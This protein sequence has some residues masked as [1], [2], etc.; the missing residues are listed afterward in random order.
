MSEL[1]GVQVGQIWRD[2]DK[3]V[4]KRTLRVIRIEGEKAIMENVLCP[5]LRSTVSIRRVKPG[6]TG[7]E[8]VR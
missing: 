6:A 2:M 3:R 1:L 5:R 8:R 7:Y 4:G